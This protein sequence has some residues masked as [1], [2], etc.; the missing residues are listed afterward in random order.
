MKKPLIIL[1]ILFSPLV[2]IIASTT[3]WEVIYDTTFE[4][5]V[6][7]GTVQRDNFNTA[8]MIL[9]PDN[10]GLNNIRMT[11]D[12]LGNYYY[13]INNNSEG[14]YHSFSFQTSLEEN[15]DLA[16]I[17]VSKKFAANSQY[18]IEFDVNKAVGGD[19]DQN[20]LRI[21]IGN[22]AALGGALDT[23]VHEVNVP[24]A[25]VLSISYTFHLP[26]DPNDPND[27]NQDNAGIV[28]QP[29]NFTFQATAQTQMINGA[30]T[31]NQYRIYNFKLSE[32]VSVPEHK[33]FSLVCGIIILVTIISRRHPNRMLAVKHAYS[34]KN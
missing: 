30:H 21:T 15:Q 22:H 17:D 24:S 8:E 25:D 18:K 19:P 33:D 34:V 27:P 32:V 2:N 31:T 6:N 5:D 7:G 26:N 9:Q 3:N 12:G 1:T 20:G 4:S 28:D 11:G 29:F 14:Q 10:D 23:I 16:T 13:F